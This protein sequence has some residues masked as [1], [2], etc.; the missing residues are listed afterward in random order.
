MLARRPGEPRPGVRI[1]HYHY[2]FDDER[3]SFARQ[4]DFLTSAYEPV[5]LTEAVGR[6]ESGDVHGREVVVTFDDGFRNQRSNAAPLLAERGIRAC[7]FLVSA[8]VSAGREDT[9]RLCRERLHLPGPVEP[10]TWEDAR[11]LIE[12]A[13]EVGSHSRSHRNLVGLAPDALADELRASR[14]EIG[15]RLDRPVVHFSAPYGE[16]HRFSP[17][18]SAAARA[19]GYASCA[20][21]QRG[22]NTT[23]AD[24]FELRRDHIEAS[25]PVAHVRYFLARS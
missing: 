18:V 23:A 9:E 25:W 10:M 6:L 13:H 16:S 22:L 2:V 21:A 20:T 15:R 4:L 1:V 7:F 12:L 19:A 17:A 14:E 5:S 8:L 3:Q 24:V 11:E